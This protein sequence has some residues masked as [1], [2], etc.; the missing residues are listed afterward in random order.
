M[1]DPGAERT[2]QLGS[3]PGPEDEEAASG[4][5]L[6]HLAKRKPANG[7]FPRDFKLP[8]RHVLRIRR[9]D[10]ERVPIQKAQRSSSLR[11]ASS[12]RRS[13]TSSASGSEPA[14]AIGFPS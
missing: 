14:S 9:A 4:G 10:W 8:Q 2:A 3:G 13:A 12:F 7:V 1:Q 5:G 11:A 6:F